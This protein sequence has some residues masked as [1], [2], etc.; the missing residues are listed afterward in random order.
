MDERPSYYS[1]VLGHAQIEFPMAESLIDLLNAGMID[2]VAPYVIWIE[3]E[4]FVF[5]HLRFIYIRDKIQFPDKSGFLSR[6]KFNS[7]DALHRD[8]AGRGY[9]RYELRL[10]SLH[11]SSSWFHV[12]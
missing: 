9:W 2:Q 1:A 10:T 5:Q 3:T 4:C 12:L 8:F 11:S 6:H 7:K